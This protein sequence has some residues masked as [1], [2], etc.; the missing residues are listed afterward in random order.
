M[1]SLC[2]RSSLRP[3]YA[4]QFTQWVRRCDRDG[5]CSTVCKRGSVQVVDWLEH[6]IATQVVSSSQFPSGFTTLQSWCFLASCKL[7]YYVREQLLVLQL[8]EATV[9]IH[10]LR[11]P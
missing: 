5:V 11:S 6:A 8:H 1:V 2:E 10:A 9:S 7:V 3:A 4:T